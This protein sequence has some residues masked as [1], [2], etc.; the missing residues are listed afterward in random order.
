[1]EDPTTLENK[2]TP[3]TTSVIS[4]GIWHM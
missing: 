2:S 1:M 4:Y 3:M